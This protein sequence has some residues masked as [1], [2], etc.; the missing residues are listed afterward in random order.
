MLGLILALTAAARAEQPPLGPD[1]SSDQ[2]LDALHDVGKSLKDFSA[3]VTMSTEDAL[4]GDVTKNVGTVWYQKKDGDE[5]RMRVFF[6]KKVVAD[7]VNDKA[8]IEYMLEKGWLTDRDYL[9]KVEVQRQVLKPGQKMNPLKLGEGPFPLPIGQEREEVLKQ[10]DVKKMEAKKEDPDG[11]VHIQ[12]VPKPGTQFVRKFARVDVW[13]E[14]GTRFPRRIAV[15]QRNPAGQETDTR[16]TDL[17]KIKLNAGLRD[18]DFK[19]PEIQGW[20]KKTESLDQP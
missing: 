1:S 5:T 9:H 7:K 17:E 15:T 8:K 11:T 6:D 13:V 20:T 16:T 19:L 3:A 2:V 10:F 14:S 12:L 18:E 4:T